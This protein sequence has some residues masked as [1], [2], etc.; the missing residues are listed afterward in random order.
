MPFMTY[1]INIL[2]HYST[3]LRQRA[4]L[5]QAW[6][7]SCVVAL[8]GDLEQYELGKECAHGN[9]VSTRFVVD[10]REIEESHHPIDPCVLCFLSASLS[11]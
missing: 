11:H 8:V 2:V 3:R 9:Y 10:D 4:S 7:S 6:R 5:Q 1:P